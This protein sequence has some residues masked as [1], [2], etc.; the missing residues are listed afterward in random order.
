MGKSA[1]FSTTPA[2]NPTTGIT[3]IE[4]S[5]PSLKSVANLERSGYVN[6]VSGRVYNSCNHLFC[7][8]KFTLTRHCIRFENKIFRVILFWFAQGDTLP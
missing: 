5:V 1:A 7:H 3:T 8:S 2:S 4:L 6:K